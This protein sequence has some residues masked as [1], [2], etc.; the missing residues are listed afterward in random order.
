MVHREDE[1]ILGGQSVHGLQGL[2]GARLG[3]LVLEGGSKVE[4][5]RGIRAEIQLLL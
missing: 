5:R 1:W 2:V 3:G 4:A